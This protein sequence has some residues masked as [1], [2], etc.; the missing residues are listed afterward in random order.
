[1]PRSLT[2][3]THALTGGEKPRMVVQ[4]THEQYSCFL[5]DFVSCDTN[6]DGSLEK[7]EAMYPLRS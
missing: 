1:M 6:G 2:E 4:L 5:S 3:N 7:N